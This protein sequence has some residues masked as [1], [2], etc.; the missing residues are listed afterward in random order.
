MN[1]KPCDIF[2]VDD[3]RYLR[4]ELVI[5]LEKADY[6]V[7]A[8]ESI[9]SCRNEL[10]Q[11]TPLLILLD[12]QLPDGNGVE[13]LKEIRNME[14]Y[15]EIVMISGAASL[16][17]AAD[18][19]KLGA[20]DFLEK[21]FEP[22]RLLSIVRNCV[23]IARLKQ[24]NARHIQDKLSEFEI[25]G[26]SSVTREIIEQIKQIANI[27]ARVLITGESGTGKEL[28]AGQIH[29]RSRRALG[30]F[31]K[32]NCSAM[33]HDLIE[34]ELFG[35]EKGAF[36]GAIGKR[37]GKFAAAD[38]GSLLLDEIGDMPVTSQ[39]KLL[40]TLETGVI[41]PIGS[42]DSI[43]IDVRLISSSNRNLDDLLRRGEFRSDLLYRINT[44]PIHLSP[45]RDRREDIPIL[46][47]HFL[48]L[49]ASQNIETATKFDDGV[50][51]LL[52]AHDWP[53]NVRELRNVIERAFYMSTDGKI[54]SD[55]TR[56]FL[57]NKDD[58][59]APDANTNE[60]NRLTSAVAQFERSYLKSELREVDGNVSR[61][62]KKLQMDRGN[63]YRK[64]KK[65]G[66]L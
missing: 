7:S 47:N 64:L 1:N 58:T 46:A 8:H 60:H 49:L 2:V 4:D 51:E 24:A 57:D 10:A 42:A 34:S 56:T 29:F 41:E 3:D 43:S 23:E 15:P 62:A 11:R 17:E 61:L 30:P 52:I 37:Q 31:V 65:L 66:L 53:G 38:G 22:Q 40:R 55:Q 18:S 27:D 48:T 32:I 9:S 5:L 35:H 44:I 45:L 16:Q 6:T 39:P 26:E 54:T 50:M 19:V 33:P 25:V 28:V 36:T 21:P 59:I 12:I 20:A 63:L 13:F 14:H